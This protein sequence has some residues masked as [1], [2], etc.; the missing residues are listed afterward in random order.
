M[1]TTSTQCSVLRSRFSLIEEAGMALSTMSISTEGVLNWARKAFP[2]AGGRDA[3]A[4]L[5]HAF[6][7]QTL[8][9]R[10]LNPADQNLGSSIEV[11]P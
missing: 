3:M 1:R 9:G 6:S 4:A 7:T 10:A 11:L 5:I 2:G 8:D